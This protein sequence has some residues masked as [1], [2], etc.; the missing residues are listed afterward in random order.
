MAN[1]FKE[2]C[3][4]WQANVLSV[5]AQDLFL[6]ERMEMIRIGNNIEYYFLAP[7]IRCRNIV[8]HFGHIIQFADD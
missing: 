4:Q 5:C 3:L 1:K 2:A 7:A 8:Y 6:I